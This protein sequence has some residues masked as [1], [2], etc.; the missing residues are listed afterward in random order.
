MYVGRCGIHNVKYLRETRW[1]LCSTASHVSLAEAR[2]SCI[3][4]DPCDVSVHPVLHAWVIG[5]ATPFPP[6][7]HS[8]NANIVVGY[9]SCFHKRGSKNHNEIS[10][11]YS[12]NNSCK[13][14]F[15]HTLIGESLCEKQPDFFLNNWYWSNELSSLLAMKVCNSTFAFINVEWFVSVA[16]LCDRIMNY[17]IARQ[18]NVGGYRS[19]IHYRNR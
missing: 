4:F 12:F 10:R 16:P 8:W 6:R 14:T 3:S 19:I 7:H 15:T 1:S 11:S 5:Q 13:H 9:V 17:T 18:E 2:V